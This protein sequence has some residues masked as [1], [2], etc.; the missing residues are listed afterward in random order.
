MA[1]KMICSW[2]AN[3]SFEKCPGHEPHTF[4]PELCEAGCGYD[5]APN[6]KCVP[7]RPKT[8]RSHK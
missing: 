3:C 4:D 8:K 6:A 2:A 5:K 1:K 7:Y